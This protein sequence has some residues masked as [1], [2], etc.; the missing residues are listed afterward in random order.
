MHNIVDSNRTQFYTEKAISNIFNRLK[1][2]DGLLI[3]FYM[4]TACYRSLQ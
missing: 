1:L 3:N 4:M 2:T